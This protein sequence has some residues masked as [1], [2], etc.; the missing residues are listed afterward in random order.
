MNTLWQVYNVRN[1]AS[2]ISIGLQE[3]FICSPSDSHSHSTNDISLPVRPPILPTV[4]VTPCAALLRA[5]PP[6]EDTFESPSEAFD[7]ALEAV[8]F[9]L[10]AV[11]FATSVVEA[12][13]RFVW[14]VTKRVCRSINR[15]G[16]DKDMQGMY[17]SKQAP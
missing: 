13:R 14:R 12:C 3:I 6:D 10:A 1:N 16:A 9:D 2:M 7:V 5:D 4:L 17:L 11:S 15:D 8:S